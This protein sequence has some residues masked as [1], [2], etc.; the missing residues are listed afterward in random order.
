MTIVPKDGY[1]MCTVQYTAKKLSMKAKE[2]WNNNLMRLSEQSLETV[3][4]FKE[5]SRNFII[6]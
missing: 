6:I 1:D 2:R 3:T 4:V 5:A